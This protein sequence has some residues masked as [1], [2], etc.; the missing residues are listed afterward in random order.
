MTGVGP[1]GIAWQLSSDNLTI[2]GNRI[3]G[4]TRYVDDPT[5][6]SANCGVSITSGT[7]RP[8]KEA[9]LAAN[10]IDVD[11]EG[12]TIAEQVCGAPANRA[13]AAS[14]TRQ[15][16]GLTCNFASTSTDPDADGA[17]RSYGWA[18]GNGQTSTAANPQRIQY[19]AAGSYTVTLT[20]TDNHGATNTK[21]EA[22]AV[23]AANVRPVASFR[24]TCTG[25]SCTFTNT[26]TDP[27][28]DAIASSDWRLS[29]ST[30]WTTVSGAGNLTRTIAAGS[31]L[32]ADLKVKDNGSPAL[33][34]SV[35]TQSG[36]R[37]MTL[38]V[39]K[40]SAGSAGNRAVLTWTGHRVAGG[41]VQIYRG[42]STSPLLMTEDDGSWSDPTAYKGV[43]QR[44]QVC[45]SG[46]RTICTTVVSVGL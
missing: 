26:S 24:Y 35:A 46:D 36:V 1:I 22:I 25:T 28:G 37:P 20:V 19:A 14:F 9:L 17:I 12:P 6:P 2:T 23:K 4:F 16:D 27:D 11:T 43:T 3:T 44:Y 7:A 29:N 40:T 8:S 45:R 10:T 15:C 30:A 31:N 42:G 5:E 33:E 41:S 34:S 32:S 38:T 13:P 18:F 21:S 39:Q